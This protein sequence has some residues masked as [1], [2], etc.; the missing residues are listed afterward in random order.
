MRLRTRRGSPDEPVD[1]EVR[2]PRRRGAAVGVIGVIAGKVL[3][4]AG[5]GAPQ[6]PQRRAHEAP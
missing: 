1:A 5:Y 4:L 6:S 3:A 2:A